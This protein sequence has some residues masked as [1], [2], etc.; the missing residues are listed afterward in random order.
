MINKNLL[1]AVCVGMISAVILGILFADQ[2]D[3]KH[4]PLLLT[5]P[6]T[7]YTAGESVI[8]AI[9]NKGLYP[10]S[11]PNDAFGV[12]VTDSKGLIVWRPSHGEKYETIEPNQVQ[13]ISWD[14]TNF[15]TG[16]YTIWSHVSIISASIM[17][18][19]I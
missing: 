3:N 2:T 1:M 4:L 19:I 14:T 13:T 17:I 10:L 15:A 5:I 12:S 8:I 18:E 16:T 11:F 7:E 9:K 6:K